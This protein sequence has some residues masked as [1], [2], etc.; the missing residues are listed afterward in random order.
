MCLPS[1]A[2]RSKSCRAG[3]TERS[4]DMNFVIGALCFIAGY[5]ICHVGAF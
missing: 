1:S 3:W 5:L 2:K 4:E